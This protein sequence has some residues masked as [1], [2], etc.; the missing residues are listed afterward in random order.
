MSNPIA[1]TAEYFSDQELK[2]KHNINSKPNLRIFPSQNLTSAPEDLL[3]PESPESRR[4]Q[5]KQQ[6][7]FDPKLQWQ[8]VLKRLPINHH[9]ED[10]NSSS[11]SSSSDVSDNEQPN[12]YEMQAKKPYFNEEDNNLPDADDIEERNDER[13]NT[14]DDNIKRNDNDDDKNFF[15]HPFDEQQQT[16]P[17]QDIVS[18]EDPSSTTSMFPTVDAAAAEQEQ[19]EKGKARKHWG[20]TLDKVRLIANLHTLPRHSKQNTQ[21][22]SSL[23]PYYPPLF[24]PVFIALSKDNHGHRWVS[25]FLELVFV[26]YLY[27]ILL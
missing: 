12:S 27:K 23:A 4:P 7:E 8:R 25:L 11:S 24:D 10:S 18:P 16:Q 2:K 20:T 13:L 26:V 3:S 9:Y 17:Q 22:T 19:K 6:N 5:I 1:D 14:D 15:Q 21:M